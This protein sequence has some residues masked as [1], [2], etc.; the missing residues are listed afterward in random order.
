MQVKLIN[1]L[2]KEFTNSKQELV[3]G[4]QLTFLNERSGETFKHFVGNE[5]LKG[6]DPKQICKISGKDLDI[7]TTAKTFQGKTRIVLDEIRELE[8]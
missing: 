6:F 3:R 5:N 1:M 4:F 2:E 7:S 8:D